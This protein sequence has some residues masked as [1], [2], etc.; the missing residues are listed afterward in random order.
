VRS[1]FAFFKHYL[2]QLGFLDGSRGLVAAITRAQ[3]CFWRYLGAGW[4]RA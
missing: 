2:L 3:E 4:E 1:G